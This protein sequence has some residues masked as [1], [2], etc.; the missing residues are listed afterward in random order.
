MQGESEL[1]QQGAIEAAQNPE[2]S[3]TANDAEKVMLDESQKAGVVALSFNPDASP[4]EKRLKAKEVTLLPLQPPTFCKLT[5]D[6]TGHPRRSTPTTQGRSYRDR[7]RRWLYVEYRPAYA[8]QGW[9]D[10]VFDYRRRQASGQHEN[11]GRR[12]CRDGRETRLGA[13][14]RLA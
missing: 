9:G 13:Q 7:H 8:V 5:L 1:K 10:Y 6:I 2:S 14:V 11:Q 4:E 12:G 3:V